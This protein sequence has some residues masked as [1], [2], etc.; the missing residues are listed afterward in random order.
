MPA[1]AYYAPAVS[2]AVGKG[3]TSGTGGSYFSPD[4]VVTRGQAVTFL[5]R[6]A[7]QPKV[8]VSVNPF[9]DVVAGAYY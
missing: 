1:G 9:P 5:W 4:M 6:A 3:I 2:W 8:N 7:G